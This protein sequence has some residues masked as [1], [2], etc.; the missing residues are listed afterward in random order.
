[1]VQ[2]RLE[3]QKGRIEAAEHTIRSIVNQ[4]NSDVWVCAQAWYELGL[5]LDRRGKYDEAMAAIIQA[6]ALLNSQAE[7]FLNELR[8]V[9][10]RLQVMREN[11]RPETV[12]RWL[13]SASSL[14]P[15]RRLALLGG[16]PRSGTTLLEQVLDS[17]PGIISLEE[18]TIFHNVAYMPLVHRLPDDAPML[19]VLESVPLDALQHS[20]ANYFYK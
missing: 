4:P 16:H 17:H 10:Q 15:P 19:S 6:K 5:I 12:Q 9:R 7:P 14:S 13:D 11:L 18:T 3:R 2:S 8:I 1:M 20:R